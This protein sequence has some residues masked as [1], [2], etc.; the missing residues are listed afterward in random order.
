MSLMVCST[1]KNSF[2][3]DK[4]PDLGGDAVCEFCMTGESIKEAKEKLIAKTDAIAKKMLDVTGVEGT[5]P[6]LNSVVSAIYKE[7]GGPVG[8]A[9]S[10][11]WMMDEFMGRK[12]IPVQAANVMLQFM[13]IHFQLETKDEDFD[14]KKMTDEQIRREQDLAMMQLVL[15]ASEN[16]LRRDALSAML[17]KQG[18]RMEKMDD[19]ELTQSVLRR[20]EEEV[21]PPAMRKF[22]L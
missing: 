12:V 13:K 3:E 7:F 9:Q 15:E 4:F 10:F 5:V 18:Y 21:D 20:V 8:F 11:K 19:K 1:C 14:L 16:P 17:E 2:P 22:P 6:K